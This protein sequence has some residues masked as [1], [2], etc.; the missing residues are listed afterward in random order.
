MAKPMLSRSTIAV[1]IITRRLAK[2]FQARNTVRLDIQGYHA[3]NS[4]P[5]LYME[6]PKLFFEK[7]LDSFLK[8]SILA[9][10]KGAVS[11]LRKT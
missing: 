7:I 8:A 2:I 6:P 11:V 5:Y 4:F 9:F 1:R 10:V 3:R